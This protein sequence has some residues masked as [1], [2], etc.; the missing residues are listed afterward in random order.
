MKYLFILVSAL[1]LSLP[2]LNAQY[3]P[4]AYPSGSGNPNGFHRNDDIQNPMP[5]QG[6]TIAY[7]SSDSIPKWVSTIA[8]PFPFW[9]NK[10]QKN[11]VKISNNGIITFDTTIEQL[12]SD[13]TISLPKNGAPN[14][15][16]YLLG[17]FSKVNQASIML[18]PSARTPMIRTRM[19]GFT[20]NRQFWIS[21]TGFSFLHEDKNKASICNWSVMLEE[22]SNFIY[23]IDHSTFTFDISQNGLRPDTS[24]IGL[25]IGLQINDSTGVM[26]LGRTQSKVLNPRI[27]LE[28]DFNGE[29]NAYYV[30][31]P[32]DAI[33]RNDLSITDIGLGDLTPGS[34]A[35]INIPVT[36]LNN[37]SDTVKSF[38][39]RYVQSMSLP[40]DTV[41]HEVIPPSS[42]I[43]CLTALWKPTESKR[44]QLT[45]WAD[46]INGNNQDD[47]VIN[48]TAF[49]LTAYMVNP[50]KK[51]VLVEYFTSPSCGDCP[52]TYTAIDSAIKNV[53]DVNILS[54]HIGEG[55]LNNSTF[56]TLALNYEATKGSVLI[57]RTYFK[58][59]SQQTVLTV[60]R[61]TAFSTGKPISDAL[62]TAFTVPTPLDLRVYHVFHNPTRMLT[63]TFYATFEAE[64]SGDFRVNAMVVEDTITGDSRFDQSNAMAGDTLIPIWGNAPSSISGFKHTNVVRMILDS[65]SIVGSP[66]SIAFDTKIGKTYLCSYTAKIPSELNIKKLYLQGFVLDYNP[67]P[68]FGKV[69]NSI[70]SALRTSITT[71]DEE[72]E[73]HALSIFPQP[74]TDKVMIK[75]TLPQGMIELEIYSL[76]G[77]S[78]FKEVMHHSGSEQ[79]VFQ[80]DVS[81]FPPGMYMI[82]LK[83][84][85]THVHHIMRI[86]R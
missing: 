19:Y 71:I 45:C 63:C 16:L 3:I 21:F 69:L 57:D 86:V 29:D 66:D 76:L 18:N 56:D 4:L 74:V 32:I 13:T 6:W 51:T 81:S 43:V 54:Y 49:A 50:P 38:R 82:S 65:T 24:N 60:P 73:S 25:S 42:S 28:P 20:P 62:K 68:L 47:Y 48:D 53:Q 36:V 15:A 70:S 77:T 80:Q 78:L 79:F 9:F 37:G 17:L 22:S 83:S 23:V 67:D 12:P 61:N 10:Q 11:A 39:L 52:R 8:L 72:K 44:Y 31:R 5:G 30:F 55:P 75:G 14:S 2:K 46:S 1:C 84:N 7:N 34:N 85:G 40:I 41:I 58:T 33:P 27:G 64:M 35:G 26:L 59:L